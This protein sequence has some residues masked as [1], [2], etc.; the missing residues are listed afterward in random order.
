MTAEQ[1][2]VTIRDGAIARLAEICAD[3]KPTYTADG[4]TIDWSGYAAE[5]RKTIDWCNAQLA[6]PVEIRSQA[7]P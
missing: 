1:D 5:L 4:R 6:G 2:L 3:P 7:I